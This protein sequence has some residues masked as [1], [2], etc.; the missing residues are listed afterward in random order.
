M[1]STLICAFWESLDFCKKDEL[2]SSPGNRQRGSCV[3]QCCRELKAT[4]PE[5]CE[6]P[7]VWRA[8]SKGE[9]Q[10]I[11]LRF[12]IVCFEC[13]FFCA[14]QVGSGV[15]EEYST[16]HYCHHCLHAVQL[17]EEH[18]CGSVPLR[19]W[20]AWSAWSYFWMYNIQSCRARGH[21]LN[22][23][24]FYSCS[25]CIVQRTESQLLF[26]TFTV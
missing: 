8:L 20:W 9:P 11:L 17:R 10:V 22:I 15:K 6:M 23:S 1:P 5:H 3:G 4:M 19:F 2:G 12:C 16:E 7:K 21:S 25:T 13:K 24:C 14:P 26:L 18:F